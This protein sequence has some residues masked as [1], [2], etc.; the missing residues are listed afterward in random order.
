MAKMLENHFPT[1]VVVL[2]FEKYLIKQPR[3]SLTS[4]IIFPCKDLAVPYSRVA[5]DLYFV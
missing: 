2:D 4:S 3:M 1:E 5:G